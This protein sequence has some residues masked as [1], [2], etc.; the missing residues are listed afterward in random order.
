M[1]T[2][3]RPRVLRNRWAAGFGTAATLAGVAA[4]VFITGDRGVN[5][6][7]DAVSSRWLGSVIVLTFASFFWH[8]SVRPSIVVES[9]GLLVRNPVFVHRLPWDAITR[10]RVSGWGAMRVS[11]TSGPVYPFT[12]SRSLLAA[13]SGAH[14]A[15]SALRI[16][17]EAER[18]SRPDTDLGVRRTRFSIVIVPLLIAWLLVGALAA[19]A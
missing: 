9:W 15:N 18:A 5:G 11:T 8:V 12:F 6:V 7:N 16:I 3:R 4:A 13:V 1:R 2:T 19:L 14:S 10:V 17:E